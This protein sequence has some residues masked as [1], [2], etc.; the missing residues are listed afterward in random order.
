M[1]N[2]N[3]KAMLVVCNSEKVNYPKRQCKL[4]SIVKPE[5]LKEIITS[6][7][8]MFTEQCR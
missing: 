8:F 5:K 7:K 6:E 2:C 3:E 1:I 4:S